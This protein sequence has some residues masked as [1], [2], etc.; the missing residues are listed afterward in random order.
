MAERR[1]M[2]SGLSLSDMATEGGCCLNVAV[3]GGAGRACASV[4]STVASWATEALGV[5]GDTGGRFGD[6]DSDRLRER[7]E[8]DEASLEDAGRA[9][10]FVSTRSAGMTAR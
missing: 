8:A 5:M 9:F 10:A 3:G 1:A 2:T 7:S 6:A 4:R